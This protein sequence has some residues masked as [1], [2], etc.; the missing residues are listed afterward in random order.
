MRLLVDSLL[1]CYQ[2]TEDEDEQGEGNGVEEKP[3]EG[4]PIVRSPPPLIRSSQ[5]GIDVC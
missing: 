5:S 1:I 2:T 4:R 3:D